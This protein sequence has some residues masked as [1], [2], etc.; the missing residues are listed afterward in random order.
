MDFFINHSGFF[1]GVFLVILLAVIGYFADKSEN[2][3]KSNTVENKD[4]NVDDKSAIENNSLISIESGLGVDTLENKVDEA[5]NVEDNSLVSIESGLGVN[6]VDNYD[7]NSSV[8]YTSDI[9]IS[10]PFNSSD[11]ES[12]DLS[13][14]DLEKKNYES[15]VKEHSKNDD[16]NFYY[17]NTDDS[18]VL[19]FSAADYSDIDN[20]DIVSSDASSQVDVSPIDNIGV[21]NKTFELVQ[22]NLPADEIFENPSLDA[23]LDIADNNEVVNDNVVTSS[24]EVSDS[25][26]TFD[27]YN[28][29]HLFDNETE[30]DVQDSNQFAFSI[31]NDL[32]NDASLL[33]NTDNSSDSTL[34][35]SS[36]IDN[37]STS[38]DIW[39]F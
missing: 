30:S 35:E 12:I 2:A 18:D 4:S 26:N 8:S 22:E 34:E 9:G 7:V 37:S 23:S 17:S 5:N 36:A 1:F 19:D 6:N 10:G 24:D 33:N 39:K 29:D 16:E 38:E 21:P 25:S 27:Q 32:N 15:I 28:S 14:E 13:L 31:Y 3:K 11:F 20:N